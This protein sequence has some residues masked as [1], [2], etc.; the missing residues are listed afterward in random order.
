MG[1]GFTVKQPEHEP[2]CVSGLV[3]VT[4]LDV[5]AAFDATVT[6]SVSEV[7]ETNVVELTVIPVPEKDA[8]APF[9]N[10]VPVIVSD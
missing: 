4:F 8:V 9:T 10:P 2:V 6:F 3:T 1:P 5:V 7:E